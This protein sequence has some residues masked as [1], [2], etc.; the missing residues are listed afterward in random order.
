MDKEG[1]KKIKQTLTNLSEQGVKDVQV[2]SKIHSLWRAQ[3]FFIFQPLL[4]K[5]IKL[6]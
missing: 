2:R 1:H 6:N 5:H 3:F 4:F